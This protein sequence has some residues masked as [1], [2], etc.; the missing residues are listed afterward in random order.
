MVTS[1]F[2]GFKDIIKNIKSFVLFLLTI[3]FTTI[4]AILLIKSIIFDFFVVN[5]Q[6]IKRVKGNIYYAVPI[7]LIEDNYIDISK[8]LDSLYTNGVSTYF[9]SSFLSEKFK[10]NVFVYDG[11]SDKNL[12][13][14]FYW[15][16]NK[17]FDINKLE[18]IIKEFYVVNIKEK[19]MK[20]NDRFYMSMKEFDENYIVIEINSNEWENY[21]KYRLNKSDIMEMVGNTKIEDE[22]IEEELINKFDNIFKNTSLKIIEQKDSSKIN[23][24]KLTENQFIFLYIFPY[25][26]SL[27]FLVVFS[28]IYFYNNLF[29]RLKKE[30][31][32]HYIY[33]SK[34]IYTFFRGSILIFIILLINFLL[35]NFTNKFLIN[36]IFYINLGICIFFFII[37]E[38]N[39]IYQIFKLNK[40]GVY[41]VGI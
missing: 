5:N 12:N 4:L 2:L 8:K 17:N 29:I 18:N 39:L 33:G 1:L 11:R 10:E 21:T 25:F 26:L 22:N 16:L 32:I 14:K 41:N 37:F 40:E 3:F 24:K 6:E 31:I 27:I 7:S 9:L 23:E 30:Y 34:N 19:N 38:I 28:F 15:I 35:I 20:I 13:N 36:I